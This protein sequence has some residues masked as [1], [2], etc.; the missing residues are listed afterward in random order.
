MRSN[1]FLKTKYI[2]VLARKYEAYSRLTAC[3]CRFPLPQIIFSL[4]RPCFL[5]PPH[6]PV[7]FQI[8][9]FLWAAGCECLG[10]LCYYTGCECLGLL[11]YFMLLYRVWVLMVILLLYVTIQGVSAY[12]YYVTLCYYT[13]RECLGLCYFML[14]CKVWVLRVIM[15][16]YVTIQGVNA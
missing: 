1:K 3:N 9:T 4:V 7:G 6:P 12:G 5:L 16:L 2:C 15:L 11:R 13:G 14:L 8:Y 10:L